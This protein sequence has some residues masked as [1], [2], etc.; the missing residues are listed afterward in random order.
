MKRNRKQ[1]GYL[2]RKGSCWLLNYWDTVLVEEAELQPDGSV[3]KK[4]VSKRKLRAKKIASYPEYRSKIAVRPLV[5]EFL[6]KIN[7]GRLQPESTMTLAQFWE[8]TYW[9]YVQLHK[10]PATAR[11]YRDVWLPYL[12]PRCGQIRLRDFRTCDGERI[13]AEIDRQQGL[14]HNSLKHI[15]SLL[16]GMFKH[17][18]RQGVLDGINPMQDVSIPKGKETQETHAHS[19]DEIMQILSALSDP[20]ATIIATAAF[21]GLSRGELRGLQWQDYTGNE[22]NVQRAVW[23]GNNGTKTRLHITDP[24]TR[25]RKAPVP[26]IGLL[27]DMLDNFRL[28][29]GSPS[30]GWIFP[31]LKGDRPLNFNNLVNRVI[32]P[33]LKEAGLQWH[34]WHAFRRGLGTNLY[35]LGVPDKTVQAILRHSNVS[36]TMTYYVKP[37]QQDTI[38]A[39]Q[40]LEQHVSLR[41]AETRIQ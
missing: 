11:G 25:K 22:I 16:S 39:M 19:L 9:P 5:E 4:L 20:A 18:K 33:T 27:K 21:A 15:K 2:R 30:S 26:V 6:I 29:Q 1:K 31:N 3:K 32:K 40:R 24:K 41:K 8:S 34:G 23:E 36:T 38:N 12:Q 35:S 13:L 10:R 17:A 7:S 37:V 28:M 14:S